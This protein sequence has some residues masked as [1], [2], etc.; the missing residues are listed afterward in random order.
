LTPLALNYDF[1]LLT[2]ASPAPDGTA[3]MDIKPGSGS[4]AT[5][6]LLTAGYPA[7]KPAQTMWQV[8][9]PCASFSSP[10]ASTQLAAVQH[11]PSCLAGWL[12]E[13]AF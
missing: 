5:Y 6:N 7:D 9:S 3:Y 4:A 10:P 8:G 13:R 1:G 11:A 12:C 2:L